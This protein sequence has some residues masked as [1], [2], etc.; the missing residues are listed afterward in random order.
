MTLYALIWHS[1]PLSDFDIAFE[2]THSLFAEHSSLGP[3]WLWEHQS[4]PLCCS[5]LSWPF[6]RFLCMRGLVKS[7]EVTVSAAC[8]HPSS[9]LYEVPS[10]HFI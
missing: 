9:V 10:T 5:P 1:A 3:A 2:G 8:L 4:V 6:F 7:S